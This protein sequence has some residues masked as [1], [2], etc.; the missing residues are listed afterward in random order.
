MTLSSGDFITDNHGWAELLPD[1]APAPPLQGAHNFDWV[2]VGAGVTG[3]SCARQ[4]AA[5]YPEHKIALL[6]ARQVGQGASGRNSGFAVAVSHFPG[7]FDASQKPNY[8]RV[9]RINQAGLAILE[10]QVLGL[11]IDCQWQTDGFHHPA[12]D[13]MAVAEQENFVRYLNEMEVEHTVLDQAGLADR[14]GTQLYQ[15]GVHVHAGVLVQPAALVR[16]LADNLPANV[17]LAE[18]CPVLEIEDGGAPS[19]QLVAGRISAKKIIVAA[20]YEMEKLGIQRRRII[21]S[22]LAGSFTRKLDAAELDSLGSLRTWGVLSLHGGGAT[23]RLTTDG[24]ISLR[25]TAEYN[26]GVLLSDA[27]LQQRQMFHRESF[28]KRFPQLA[29]VPFEFAWSGVEGISRNSTNFFGRYGS[30]VY[31]AGGYN[32]SGVSRGTAFGAAIADYAC[33]EQSLLIDDCLACEPASWIPPR[34]FLD[35][36]AAFTV[37]SRFRGVGQDR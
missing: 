4:L 8:Q 1:W 32:G 24:R 17:T 18:N 31:F 15:A 11:G 34:P 7:P 37:R 14:L 26:G 35:I 27:Q 23:V 3:L 33:G 20:N 25:N 2:V 19:V 10:K 29:H 36:G 6:D 21:G 30:N 16:G 13:R 9:N 28:E 12:A 5:R 22:T